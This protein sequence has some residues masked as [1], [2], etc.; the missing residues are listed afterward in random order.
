MGIAHVPDKR[1]GQITEYIIP[2]KIIPGVVEFVDIAGLE[3]VQKQQEN[4]VRLKKSND[5][6]ISEKAKATEP[7]LTLL[8]QAMEEG[9]TRTPGDPG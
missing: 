8:I 6:K 1:L 4:L 7:V 5:K 2:Q 9:D 3:T